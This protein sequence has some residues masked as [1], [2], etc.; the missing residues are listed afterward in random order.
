MLVPPPPK[1]DWPAGRLVVENMR[2][3]GLLNVGVAGAWKGLMGRSIK[4][5]QQQKAATDVGRLTGASEA[6][7]ELGKQEK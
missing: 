6:A 1:R 5:D 4:T 3:F 7:E 2:A